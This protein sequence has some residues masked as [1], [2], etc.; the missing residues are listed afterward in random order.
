MKLQNMIVI[1]SIIIIPVTLILSAYIGV[2]IDTSM[3]VQQYDTK[4]IDATHDAIVAFELNTMNN[5]Y[6]TNA[7]SI[8]RDIKASVNTFSTSLATNFGIPGSNTSSIMSYIP[9]LVFTLYDGYYI[10]SPHEYNYETM[11]F[12]NAGNQTIQQKTGYEHILK[13]YVHYTTR[14]KTLTN[15]IVVNY[16]LDNYVTIY[17]KLGN[18]YIS[19]SGYLIDISADKIVL[20]ANG[21]VVG[22]KINGI[23]LSTNEIESLS[24]QNENKQI[25][26]KQSN[27]MQKYY[28]EAYEFTK[29][30]KSETILLST[31]TPKNAIN[32][33]GN[34]YEQF[35]NDD[36]QILNISS[37]NDPEKREAAFTQHKR[38]VMKLSILENLNNAISV[39]NIHSPSLGTHANFK[40]PILTD[41]DWEKILTNVNMISFMQ[42]MPV[43]TK[44]Y[45]N[46]SIVTS[47]QNKQYINPNSIYF[48]DNTNTYHRIN[49]PVLR[50]NVQNGSFVTGYK[51]LDF[52]RMQNKQDNTKYYYKHPQYACYT[53]IVNSLNEDIRLEEV[54][55]VDTVLHRLMQSYY[56]ALARERYELDKITKMLNYPNTN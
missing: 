48:V 4:L 21:K 51:S 22:Y 36:T 15:D 23:T 32:S 18:T 1:F 14:Y 8:R 19:R 37:K 5:V 52:R 46:Y 49:C 34:K 12:D 38:E 3:L 9:A 11:E 16:S 44:I 30:V 56:S 6:S 29:W 47:T 53:C 45:N 39:Y 28:Q 20:D 13:P 27:S 26:S 33:E 50:Q 25:I 7:D 41:D 55:A 17:G 54:D 35:Q 2:Q 40:M 31:V 42:G 43:G 24:E 10:Y